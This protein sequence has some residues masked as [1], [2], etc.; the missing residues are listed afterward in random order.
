MLSLQELLGQEQGTQA[1]DQ[2]RTEMNDAGARSNFELAAE[3]QRRIARLEKLAKPAAA[4]VRRLDHWQALLV[5]PA[6]DRDRAVIALFDRGGLFRVAE[7]EIKDDRAMIS[8]AQRAGAF[9]AHSSPPRINGLHT[10]D[11]AIGTI[12]AVSRWLF[13]ADRKRKGGAVGPVHGAF[14]PRA[15]AAAARS[16]ARTKSSEPTIDPNEIEAS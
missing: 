4:R 16:F 6:T 2:I 5:L 7:V 8:A 3:I 11:D 10:D 13:L 12:A 9:I 15:L 1:V 14:D